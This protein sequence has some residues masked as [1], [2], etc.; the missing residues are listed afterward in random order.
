M[1]INEFLN[2][3]EEDGV[4]EVPDNDKFIEYLIEI[5]RESS[6]VHVVDDSEANDSEADDSV[7]LPIVNS[8][9]VYKKVAELRLKSNISAGQSLKL[10]IFALGGEK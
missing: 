9:H 4:Y 10:R 2:N 5:Y 1:S 8:S 3:P 6:D 7:E